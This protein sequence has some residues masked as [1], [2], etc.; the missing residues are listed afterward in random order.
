MDALFDLKKRTMVKAGLS[1]S[2]IRIA[3]VPI[4]KRKQSLM[5]GMTNSVSVTELGG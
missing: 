5:T 3:D 1:A 2:T 4:E